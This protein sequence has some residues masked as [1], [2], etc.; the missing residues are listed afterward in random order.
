M[1]PLFMENSA[2]VQLKSKD[3]LRPTIIDGVYQNLTLTAMILSGLQV[4]LLCPNPLRL[5]PLLLLEA[6]LPAVPRHDQGPAHARQ[7]R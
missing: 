4:D 7:P 2:I 3:A 1:N 6:H 5:L